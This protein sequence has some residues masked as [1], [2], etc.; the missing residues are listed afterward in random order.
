MNHPDETF[1][2]EQVNAVFD[3]ARHADGSYIPNLCRMVL[4]ERARGDWLDSVLR[5]AHCPA[6]RRFP[7]QES[8]S[9]PCGN[10]WHEEARAALARIEEVRRGQ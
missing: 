4:R 3:S 7:L 5:Q 10:G 1:T 8:I 2:D 6:C 9:L